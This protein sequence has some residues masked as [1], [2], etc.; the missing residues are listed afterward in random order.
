M[1]F[2]SSFMSYMN[3]EDNFEDELDTE[4][5]KVLRGE[6]SGG[7]INFEKN[8]ASPAVWRPQH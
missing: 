5:L 6:C 1:Q 4:E 2:V 7:F 8:L 3:K